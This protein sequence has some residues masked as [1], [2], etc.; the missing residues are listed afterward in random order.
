VLE[1]DAQ[2]GVLLGVTALG[3]GEPFVKTTAV[4]IAFDEPIE[5]QVFV[6]EPPAG[7]EVIPSGSE[8]GMS[9]F[10]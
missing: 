4:E 9:T 1:V 10:R 3:D 7:E 6:F 5:E 2:R 8:C